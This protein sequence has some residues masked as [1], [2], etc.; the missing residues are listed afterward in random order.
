MRIEPDATPFTAPV[1]GG[2]IAAQRSGIGD[3]ALLLHGGP[4]V[5][6]TLDELA[7]ELRRA[8]LTTIRFQQR[9]LAPSTVDGPFDVERQVADAIA[10][11]DIA[12]VERAWLVGHSWGGY[13]A[14][15]VASRHPER[16][17]GILAIGTLGG[18]GD[19]GGAGLGPNLL[20]RLGAEAHAEY[21]E[22]EAREEAGTAT[23]A[24]SLRGFELLWPAYFGDPA[25]AP[26]F[27]ADLTLSAACNDQTCA[28]IAPDAERLT[29]A[30][31]VSAVPAVF[32]HGELDPIEIA[33][34]ARA[35]AAVMPRAE[36]V[37]LPGVGHFPW[38]ERPGTAADALMRLV[39]LAI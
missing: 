11:L 21:A 28:S 25:T 2:V 31:T 22:I 13:L 10:V 6:E 19:G 16:V 27:P 24:D 17:M 26:P 29:Q 8:G 32:L 20:A 5:S 38:L 1:P 37:A 12:A 18:V 7:D 14:L 36:V 4:G 34:S 3:P 15:Q 30:L 9:G 39:A 23:D 33:S 35:T